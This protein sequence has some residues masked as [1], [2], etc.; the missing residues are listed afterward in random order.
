MIALVHRH[1][2]SEQRGSGTGK[3]EHACAEISLLVTF[4]AESGIFPV[5]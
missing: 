1:V 3:V 4:Q 2:Q 5:Y